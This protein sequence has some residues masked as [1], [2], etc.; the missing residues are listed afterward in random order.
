MN[1]ETFFEHPTRK[2]LTPIKDD[3][4]SNH[5]IIAGGSVLRCMMKCDEGI[6]DVDAYIIN[7]DE[8][9]DMS[10][11]EMKN[12]ARRVIMRC[13]K[14]LKP[15]HIIAT[16]TTTTLYKTKED[17]PFQIVM[18]LNND[19]N[20]VIHSFDL[21]NSRVALI[22]KS[23]W[24]L[25][26]SA[27]AEDALNL[28]NQ[29]RKKYIGVVSNLVS[30]RTPDRIRKYAK[31]LNT[32]C[33]K[34]NDWK[35]LNFT[36]ETFKDYIE[37]RSPDLN[38]EDYTYYS[39]FDKVKELEKYMMNVGD[40]PYTTLPDVEDACLV[41]GSVFKH[42]DKEFESMKPDTLRTRLDTWQGFR[43]K[44][45]WWMYQHLNDEEKKK[46]RMELERDGYDVEYTA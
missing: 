46:I 13:I 38:L 20:E 3:S 44:R 11:F 22:G 2:W 25:R 37:M 4:I 28:H 18:Q 32:D 6:H 45:N 7:E 39:S 43:L 19:Y 30:C 14:L 10:A 34:F 40:E 41:A 5:M 15:E 12:I 42:I 36:E 27:D 9:E 33:V 31:L 16:R 1:T 23:N 29:D 26:V 35:S 8:Y 24:S 17:A 21:V